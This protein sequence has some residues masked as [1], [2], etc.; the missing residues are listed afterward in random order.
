MNTRLQHAACCRTTTHVFRVVVFAVVVLLSSVCDAQVRDARGYAIKDS[1][2]VARSGAI[3]RDIY[4]LDNERVMFIGA[5]PRDYVEPAPG[6]K[7]LRYALMLWNVRTGEVTTHHRADVANGSLCIARAYVRF[8]YTPDY[9]RSPE[10]QRWYVVAGPFGR[11]ES[12]LMDAESRAAMSRHERVVNPNTCREY[13]PAKLPRL[14]YRVEPLLDGE[15]VGL[16]REPRN[17]EA[18]PWKYWPRQ[19][20]AVVLNMSREPIRIT[21]HSQ[22]GD[23]YVVDEAPR[24]VVFGENVVRRSWLMDRTGRTRDFTPPSGP[25][26]R[27]S[28]TVAPT[29][30]GLFLVSHAVSAGANGAAGGY[31][32]VDGEFVR[33]VPGLPTVFDVSPDG[34]KV[35]LAV[36]QYSRGSSPMPSVKA[37]NVCSKEF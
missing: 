7:E 25:W 5:N 33:V 32:M 12:R 24:D 3:Q 6:A 29:K 37:I 21:R 17:G 16:E 31:L 1:G 30:R 23:S 27:G 14:G 19:G 36:G 35:A 34:C 28:T 9:R 13:E 10:D 2:L 15:F 26:M 22:F 4:W 20:S 8:T 11:E 18:V